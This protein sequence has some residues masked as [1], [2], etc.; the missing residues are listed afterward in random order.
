MDELEELKAQRDALANEYKRVVTPISDQI[1]NV[2]KQITELL[3]ER[4]ELVYVDYWVYGVLATEERDTYEEAYYLAEN[5]SDSGAG[6]PTRVYGK[7]F[8]YEDWEW[9]DPAK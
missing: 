2:S 7:D 8:S 5:L 1:A 3:R 4:G 6:Y 9:P